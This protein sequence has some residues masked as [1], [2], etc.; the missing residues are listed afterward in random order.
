MVWHVGNP[1]LG[2][3]IEWESL[4]SIVSGFPGAM[5]S[6]NFG[7]GVG[8]EVGIVFFDVEN[9]GFVGLE[10]SS[11]SLDFSSSINFL[12]SGK[13]LNHQFLCQFSLSSII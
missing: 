13:V 5:S 7:G 2:W 11:L 1:G 10:C 4:L 3:G 8:F 6:S 9:M 12:S